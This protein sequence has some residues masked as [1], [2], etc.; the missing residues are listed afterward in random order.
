[1]AEYLFSCGHESTQP[2]QIYGTP[3][4]GDWLEVR[5]CRTCRVELPG[6]RIHPEHGVQRVGLV[7]FRLR[8]FEAGSDAC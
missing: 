7:R 2:V 3:N 8:H 1:M 6:W 5:A 4:V